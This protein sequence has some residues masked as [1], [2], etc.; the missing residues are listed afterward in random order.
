MPMLSGGQVSCCISKS[1][2]TA[3]KTGKNQHISFVTGLLVLVSTFYNENGKTFKQRTS[4]PLKTILSVVLRNHVLTVVCECHT[5]LTIY[6]VQAFDISHHIIYMHVL[7]LICPP[8]VVLYFKYVCPYQSP[9]KSQDETVLWFFLSYFIDGAVFEIIYTGHFSEHLFPSFY[10]N[11]HLLHHTS[12]A[13][14]AFSGVTA[15]TWS[16]FRHFI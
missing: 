11:Y 5:T 8:A 1:V 10:K 12:K 9:G 3:F 14:I 13:D 4:V 7:Q 2:L 16:S 6:Y 15:C